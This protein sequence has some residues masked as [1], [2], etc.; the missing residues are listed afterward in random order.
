MMPSGEFTWGAA[1][2]WAS[3]VALVGVI[4]RQVGPWRKQS[5]DAEKVFR[6]DLITRVTK[7]ERTLER[8][9]V[10]RE[11][12]KAV[13][14][15]KIKNLQACFDAM[16]LMMKAAPEKASE[17]IAHIEKMRADQLK[18]ETIESAAI[19]AAMLAALGDEENEA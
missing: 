17:I 5:L 16:M 19:H 1:G 10:R 8:E 7:L 13:E 12:E 4:I 2:A 3:F 11:A 18:A 14:R 9:R 15:H 6:D